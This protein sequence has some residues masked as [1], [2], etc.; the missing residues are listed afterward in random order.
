[1]NF[2]RMFLNYLFSLLFTLCLTGY[3]NV[4]MKLRIFLWHFSLLCSYVVHDLV[5]HFELTDRK[6]EV[7]LKCNSIIS[8]CPVDLNFSYEYGSVDN[9]FCV[10]FKFNF[11]LS[12]VAKN[13][14]HNT[15]FRLRRD[16][17]H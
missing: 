12:T 2:K 1:M 11:L 9:I 14:K 13:A 3:R 17:M 6:R 15:K 10:L 5:F 16:F 4:G 8:G 7:F